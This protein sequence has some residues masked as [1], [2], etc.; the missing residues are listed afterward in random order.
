[1]A[2]FISQN[3]NLC[4]EKPWTVLVDSAL[5]IVW[6]TSG[7]WLF[8]SLSFSFFSFVGFKFLI[9]IR[10]FWL[11]LFYALNFLHKVV[12]NRILFSRPIFHKRRPASTLLFRFSGPWIGLQWDDKR[13]IV[14][15]CIMQETTTTLWSFGLFT[16]KSIG[17]AIVSYRTQV[18]NATRLHFWGMVALLVFEPSFERAPMGV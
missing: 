17:L 16:G 14:W 15:F 10:V 1:M 3:R 4:I 7:Y 13:E 9:P 12:Q 8:S 11:E 6:A 18:S 5:A 2:G